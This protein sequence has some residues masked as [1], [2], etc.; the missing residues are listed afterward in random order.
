MI[1]SDQS[2][3]FL[4]F[5]DDNPLV[6]I[7]YISDLAAKC[8]ID[9]DVLSLLSVTLGCDKFKPDKIQ[10]FLR[11]EGFIPPAPQVDLSIISKVCP[12][13]TLLLWLFYN[14]YI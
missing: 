3:S 2:I 13:Q 4:C 9:R 6:G 10:Q 14:I 1:F 5:R 11:E 7:Y 8:N 12:S